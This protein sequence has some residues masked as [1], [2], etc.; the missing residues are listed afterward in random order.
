MISIL[1]N[2]NHL[3]IRKNIIE[4]IICGIVPHL[5]VGATYEIPE[6]R[7]RWNK[8]YGENNWIGFSG[9]CINNCKCI[10]Y[11]FNYLRNWKKLVSKYKFS[12][13]IFD[14]ST[15][16]FIQWWDYRIIEI[17][18]HLLTD[19]GIF[20][21]LDLDAKPEYTNLFNHFFKHVNYVKD[22]L[23][24]GA[25][26]LA[27]ATV[28]YYVL[29]IPKKNPTSKPPE[30]VIQGPMFTDQVDF[31]FDLLKN[32]INGHNQYY[33][34]NKVDWFPN[35]FVPSLDK[36]KPSGF[37]SLNQYL[38]IKN[39]LEQSHNY[40][41]FVTYRIKIVATK[42]EIKDKILKNQSFLKICVSVDLDDLKYL[43]V[44][45]FKSFYDNG[46]FLKMA[47]FAI[48][49]LHGFKSD[50]ILPKHEI[51]LNIYP[52]GIGPVLIQSIKNCLADIVKTC[53]EHKSE[54]DDR[55]IIQTK[56]N[57]EYLLPIK[58]KEHDNYLYYCYRYEYYEDS[59]FDIVKMSGDYEIYNGNHDILKHKTDNFAL[60]ILR[61]SYYDT[62]TKEEQ[63]NPL[64]YDDPFKDME[65]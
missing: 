40:I 15:V 34:L 26:H 21:F 41:T 16:K 2:I 64:H 31:H 18:T 28:S 22:G 58:S 63:H 13:I 9:N 47:T 7:D 5:V 51:I 24:P 53:R 3:M 59:Q 33:K 10:Q 36:F 48:C 23:Y 32:I 4:N 46:D 14:W 11:D 27:M 60:P 37:M 62:L 54:S 38:I 52:F 43:A 45:L 8:F 61:K 42:P 35:G 29:K 57:P 56:D 65:I 1:D 55:E 12:T 50:L 49:V 20:Y 39:Q 44:Q 25:P 19:D 30:T 17:I 6:D